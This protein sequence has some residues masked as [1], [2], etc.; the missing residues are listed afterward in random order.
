MWQGA[1]M[2]TQKE[3]LLLLQLPALKWGEGGK[4]NKIKVE[5]SG[6]NPLGRM[7]IHCKECK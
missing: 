7:P 5:F 3:D 6:K 2:Q 4:K 1:K